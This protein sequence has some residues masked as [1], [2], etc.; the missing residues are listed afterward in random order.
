MDAGVAAVVFV[1]TDEAASVLDLCPDIRDRLEGEIDMRP[2]DWF[3]A[4]DRAL[5]VQF[6]DDLDGELVSSGLLPDRSDLAGEDVA[7]R[8][9]AASEG[10]LRPLMRTLRSAMVMAV[11]RHAPAITFED[12]RDATDGYAVRLK[13]VAE[14]PFG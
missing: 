7:S 8:L 9:C 13:I 5:F 4:G 1:G 14:N 10:R 6:L 12:L 2:L 3:D 11:A